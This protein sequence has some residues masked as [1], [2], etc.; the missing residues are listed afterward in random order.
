MWYLQWKIY[1]LKNI[2]VL[3]GFLTPTCHTH[4]NTHILI[5]KNIF[6]NVSI[7]N[8]NS[9]VR[10]KGYDHNWAQHLIFPF[11]K[12]R[13]VDK[14]FLMLGQNL[15]ATSYKKD[16]KFWSIFWNA[17]PSSPVVNHSNYDINSWPCSF[18]KIIR[19]FQWMNWITYKLYS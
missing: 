14:G 18:K 7:W 13:M 19:L 16:T 4:I 3:N 1:K 12:S 15:N 5:K 11:L 8:R 10:L 2:W 17:L 6:L 9:T